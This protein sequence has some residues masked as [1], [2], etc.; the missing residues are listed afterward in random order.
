VL[1]LLW[2]SVVVAFI[3]ALCITATLAT[4]ERA[5]GQT[6]T[7]FDKL[8][9]GTANQQIVD[10]FWRMIRKS[11]ASHQQTT[12]SNMS[13][14]DKR[15]IFSRLYTARTNARLL[16]KVGLALG[17]IS[18]VGTL[19]YVGWKVYQHYFQGGDTEWDV[20][21]DS[22]TLGADALYA[23]NAVP[24]GGNKTCD[25]TGDGSTG[26]LRWI[27]HTPEHPLY[28]STEVDFLG[29]NEGTNV[30]GAAWVYTVLAGDTNGGCGP[31]AF[32]CWVLH[33]RPI[34][35]SSHASTAS[36]T[37][38]TVT[39]PG[40]AFATSC[41]VNADEAI[42]IGKFGATG[43]N[44]WC[45]TAGVAGWESQWRPQL[46]W[47]TWQTWKNIYTRVA[48]QPGTHVWEGPE[49]GTAG[50]T[51]VKRRRLIL[52]PDAI[53]EAAQVPTED[54][55]AGGTITYETNYNVPSPYTTDPLEPGS[56]SDKQGALDA[57]DTPCGRAFVNAML[58]PVGYTYPPGCINDPPGQDPE[59][60]NMTLPAPATD[61]TYASYV[62]RLR[63][64]GFLGAISK[65]VWSEEEAV[66]ELEPDAVT[67]V[68]LSA[69]AGS[70]AIYDVLTWPTTSPTV[71]VSLAITLWV[72][73]GPESG[74]GGS[75]PEDDATQPPLPPGDPTGGL[76]PN[77]PPI[78][79]S[80][81][82]DADLGSKFPFGVL[83]WLSGWLGALTTTPDAPVFS[84]DFSAVGT[85][86]GTYDLG[87]YEVDLDVLDVYMT[88]IR[89]ILAWV[90]WIGAVWWFGAHLLGLRATGDPGAAVDEAWS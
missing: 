23:G 72:N 26:C 33:L 88:T 67:R 12:I 5:A 53:T 20:W 37:S 31:V 28:P 13:N 45:S 48:A 73:P 74:G 40:A 59:T 43:S 65:R 55:P 10:D 84:F 85:P 70:G 54:T 16:P 75:F 19:G 51:G 50:W 15:Y 25:A 81:L 38:C 78:D 44:P 30:V 90:V 62:S 3:G 89:T 76:C 14:T 24:F 68:K 82:T 49:N 11:Y 27:P 69:P 80:P 6:Q 46:C 21:L 42:A 52:T 83:P 36:N 61:E 79:F 32:P 22:S 66:P 2:R 87:T 64:L 56:E 41:W 29:F 71:S 34:G 4:P 17:R 57:L 7:P 1:G 9:A 58:D 86:V 63:A 35:P 18:L 8:R 39:D 47:M 77:C 60:G